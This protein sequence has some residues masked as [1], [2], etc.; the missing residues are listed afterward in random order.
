MAG[1]EMEAS[2]TTDEDARREGGDPP[3]VATDDKAPRARGGPT[4]VEPDGQTGEGETPAAPGSA[5]GGGLGGAKG[6]LG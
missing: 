4:H 6:L 1:F 5:E 2:G 3:V